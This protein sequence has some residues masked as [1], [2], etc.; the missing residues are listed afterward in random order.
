MILAW[1]RGRLGPPREDDT[2]TLALSGGGRIRLR[3]G[4]RSARLELTSPP[5]GDRGPSTTRLDLSA[6]EARELQAAL[7]A[8]N[9]GIAA[10][11]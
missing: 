1:L 7:A 8:T 4:H 5:D 10:T 6:A 2:I 11:A 3:P 9:Q